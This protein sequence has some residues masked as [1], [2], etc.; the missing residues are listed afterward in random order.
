MTISD[1]LY[2]ILKW[3]NQYLLP[4]L[5]TLYFALSGIW[6]FP[7]TD[8][9]IG[10]LLALN[11]FLGAILGISAVT[12]IVNNLDHSS[13]RSSSLPLY[14]PISG[15]CSTVRIDVKQGMDETTYRFV[16]WI[17]TV[18]LPTLGSLYSS[19]SQ[20]WGLPFGGEI[21]GTIAAITS[22]AGILLG[23]STSQYNKNN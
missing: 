20:L 13:V 15:D 2:D 11:V 19:I 9:I 5:A 4:G 14:E 7:Y 3:C 21:L 22:F 18:L 6:E 16:R 10:T 12:Y 17:I 8:Q 1:R 23:I